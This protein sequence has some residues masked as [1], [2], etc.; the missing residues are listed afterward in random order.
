MH[1]PY[2]YKSKKSFSTERHFKHS[3][4][5][6]SYI[7]DD[8]SLSGVVRQ[9]QIRLYKTESPHRLSVWE[10]LA[11]RSVSAFFMPVYLTCR[12]CPLTIYIPGGSFL[13]H[14]FSRTCFLSNMPVRE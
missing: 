6:F 12:G 3:F 10:R 7:N 9:I 5:L 14:S 8:Y 4:T 11:V 1:N 13:L 2:T